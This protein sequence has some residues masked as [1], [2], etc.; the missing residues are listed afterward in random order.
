LLGA[1]I[2]SKLAAMRRALNRAIT[3]VGLVVATLALAAWILYDGARVD[4]AGTLGFEN[5]LSIPPLL[6]PEADREGRKVFD[7]EMQEGTIELIP[8]QRTATW[9]FNGSYLGPTL[10]ATRGD[11]VAMRVRN[12]LAETSTVHWHGMHLPAE[13]DGGPHQTIDPG[14]TWDPSWEIDQPAA[15]LWYHPHPHGDTEEHVYRGLAGMFIV[16]DPE[17]EELALP[18]EYGVDDIPLIVQDKRFEDDGEL[19]FDQG[20]I[21]P[22]GQLGDEILVNG[23]SD[24]HLDV[25][26]TRVR[27][28]LLN[29]SSARTFN[30]G[31]GDGRREF[32]LIATDG[33]LL[34]APQRVDRIQLSPGERAEI[35][36]APEPGEDLALRS[37]EPDLGAVDFLNARFVG[38]DDRFDILALRGAEEL[39]DSPPLPGAL[40]AQEGPDPSEAEGVRR[41]ELGSRD[42][43]DL[44][45]DMT[46]IDQT[47]PVDTTEIWE[48]ENRAGIPHNF[49]VHDTRFEVIEYAGE[50][51]EPAL[52]GLKDTV[53]VP[54][55]DTV[56]I[57]TRFSDYTDP[58]MPYMFHCHLLQHE[59]RGMMGQFVVVELGEDAGET[60]AHGEPGH[61]HAEDHG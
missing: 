50:P 27:L 39:R 31:L 4:T 15:T 24:P 36:V 14:E 1:N 3:I 6:E 20:L 58:S 12:E 22:I 11:E 5:E 28:R 61:N 13:A 10:R 32:D 51:P 7:L 33:G 16:D 8:G 57:V 53:L 41:F 35:V 59:D 56:R 38:A 17:A 30:F 43:N 55:G 52:R 60:P 54:P 44:K 42:I 18:D 48:I 2:R 21:S 46:R 49:H 40:I 34:A 26:T 45:M 9:G 37:F 23:T 47:V 25:S 29:A 19:S